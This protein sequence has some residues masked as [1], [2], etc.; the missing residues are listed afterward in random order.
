MSVLRRL[1]AIFHKPGSPYTPR[2]ARPEAPEFASDDT[3]PFA[4]IG[5]P[6]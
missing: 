5:D 6:R 3:Q 2:H 4:R 1:V